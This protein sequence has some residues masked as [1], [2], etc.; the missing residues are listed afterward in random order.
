M[1]KK[2]KFDQTGTNENKNKVKQHH[3]KKNYNEIKIK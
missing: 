2:K 3:F 1:C